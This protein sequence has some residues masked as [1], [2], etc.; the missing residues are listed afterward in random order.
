MRRA[1]DKTKQDGQSARLNEERALLL[2]LLSNEL[3]G[4]H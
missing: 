4:I 2:L 1:T 3:D